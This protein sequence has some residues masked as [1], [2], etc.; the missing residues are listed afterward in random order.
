MCGLNLNFPACILFRTSSYG[1]LCLGVYILFLLCL[2]MYILFIRAHGH[3]QLLHVQAHEHEHARAR[4][5]T[6]AP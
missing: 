2:G 1:I 5:H 4:T 3:T 6:H